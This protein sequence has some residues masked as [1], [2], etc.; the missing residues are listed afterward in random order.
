MTATALDLL[1]PTGRLVASYFPDDDTQTLTDRLTTYLT[2][3]YGDD[4]TNDAAAIQWAY[5]RA[6]SAIAE[7]IALS[8]ASAALPGVGSVGFNSSQPKFF[9]DLAAQARAA[10]DALTN[11]ISTAGVHQISSSS[12]PLTF[13]W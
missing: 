3:G 11:S 8:P 4:P 6:Y 5:F 2:E 1:Q 13:Q 9:A 12:S 10:Y 7:R